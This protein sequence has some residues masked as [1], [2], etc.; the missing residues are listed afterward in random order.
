MAKRKVIINVRSYEQRVAIIDD[1]SLTELYIDRADDNRLVGNIY[2]G[3]VINVVHGLKAAFVNIGAEK[4]GFLPLSEI[5]YQQLVEDAEIEVESTKELAVKEGQDIIIQVTKESYSGKGPRLTSYVSLPGK[6]VVLLINSKHIGVS[7]KIRDRNKR[8]KL[9]EI[10]KKFR[11]PRMGLILRTSAS[12]SKE[13]VIGKEIKTLT[14]E[15]RIIKEKVEDKTPI[16][17][18]KEPDL[19]LRMMR[20]LYPKNISEI[21]VDDRTTIERIT[22]YLENTS[23]NLLSKLKSYDDLEPI[24][25]HF[26]VEKEIR[27]IL[28]RK[29][30]LKSGG[31]ITIDETEALVAIDINSGRSAQEKNPEILAF[32]TN[33]EAIKEIAHQLRL[34]DIGG[35]VVIDL[36]DM[37]KRINY[38]RI[39]SELKKLLKRDRAHYK[40]GKLTSFGVLEL[41]RERT[42]QNLL[43]TIGEFCPHCGGT[44]RVLARKSILSEIERWFTQ[45]RDLLQGKTIELR[46]SPRV[47]D[48]IITHAFRKIRAIGERTS[49]NIYITPDN[50]IGEN[51]F[52]IYQLNPF[53]ELTGNE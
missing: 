1:D 20:D 45:H 48:H 49:T 5:P 52:Q 42:R 15:W 35:L 40:I 34:R 32:Q 27:K 43:A 13:D 25:D 8:Q 37:A 46:I 38:L 2:R 9:R 51:K 33:M 14:K 36:I 23:P 41:T 18:Y 17:L 22:A 19:V 44:G 47:A 50:N 21:W 26:G 53:K 30:W 10:A 3:K 29:I 11:P 7:R 31:Y 28:E 16:L 6:Y 39:I 4:N 24:F 12:L